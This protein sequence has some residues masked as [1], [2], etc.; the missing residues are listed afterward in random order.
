MEEI[1]DNTPA[2]IQEEKKSFNRER[3]DLFSPS[4]G[5]FDR[6]MAHLSKVTSFKLVFIFHI[7]IASV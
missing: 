6:Q 1:R 4:G 5:A 7:N 3:P 2:R